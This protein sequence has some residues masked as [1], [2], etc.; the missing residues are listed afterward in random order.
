MGEDYEGVVVTL[1]AF[2][3]RCLG[4]LLMVGFSVATLNGCCSTSNPQPPLTGGVSASKPAESWS[5]FDEPP[6]KPQSPSD[7]IALPRPSY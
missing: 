3:L 2:C 1:R 5:L 6:K 4:K 7:Y